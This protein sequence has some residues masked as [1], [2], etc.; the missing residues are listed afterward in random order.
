MM[1]PTA[2]GLDLS[3]PWRIELPAGEPVVG[4]IK[5]SEDACHV[6]LVGSNA[7]T[8]N[9]SLTEANN[10][11]INFTCPPNGSNYLL[12]LRWNVS[13]PNPAQEDFFIGSLRVLDSLPPLTGTL[14]WEFILLQ[15]GTLKLAFPFLHPSPLAPPSMT[16]TSACCSCEYGDASKDVCKCGH[17]GGNVFQVITLDPAY[18]NFF[19]GDFCF[20]SRA[21]GSLSKMLLRNTSSI[22]LKLFPFNN[23]ASQMPQELF[24][25]TYVGEEIHDTFI[26]FLH[27]NDGSSVPVMSPSWPDGVPNH[28][29]GSWLVQS[30]SEVVV[31]FY[32]KSA[33]ECEKGH[34]TMLLGENE[35]HEESWRED[36]SWPD[37]NNLAS[38][39][40]Y[41]NFTN[42]KVETR[43]LQ[44][45]AIFQAF[46]ETDWVLIGGIIGGLV[47]LLVLMSLLLF[48]IFYLKRRKRRK[49]PTSVNNSTYRGWLDH[50]GGT[51]ERGWK[52]GDT[53]SCIYEVIDDDGVYART[54]LRLP[55]NGNDFEKDWELENLPMEEQ[56]IYDLPPVEEDASL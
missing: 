52:D 24:H 53:D 5:A 28:V 2:T 30:E 3:R 1:Q 9:L 35:G 32:N 38:G 20:S 27:L 15:E 44:F 29:S 54:S 47:G 45:F 41:F 36:E 14:H 33:P 37:E 21:N 40:V 10:R 56:D 46:E 51:S 18:H 19:L 8:K 7:C 25:A 39:D 42:C 23:P 43:T 13:F 6:C 31:K 55:V 48:V 17:S 26:M 4:N 49:P 50:H 22:K 12:E 16:Q 11:Y 34:L